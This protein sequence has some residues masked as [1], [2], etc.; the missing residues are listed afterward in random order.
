[1]ITTQAAEAAGLQG[2]FWEMHDLIFA[3]QGEWSAL[4]TLDT[5]AWLTARAAELGLDAQRFSADLNSEAMIKKA[6]DAQD[7]ARKA[8]IGGTP[9]L[10]VNGKPY[11]G[12]RSAQALT[13]LVNLVDFIPRQFTACPPMTI[14]PAKTY[15]ATLT[16][17]KGDIVIE[18][19]PDKA[20][21]TVNSF[22]F[23]ARSGWFDNVTF[24]RVIPNFA[25]QTG[26][27]TGTG[28][29]NPGYFF[30]NEITPELTYSEPGMV[31][32]ANGGPG[33]NGSQFF[34]TYSAQQVLNGKYTVFGKVI[35]GME[36]VQ[37]L[38][39]RDP[40]AG[41]ALPDPDQIIKVSIQEK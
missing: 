24:H 14:D 23:L 33:T 6:Q 28:K 31:G 22:I 11:E 39:P 18:L 10:L 21:V 15:T 36:V 7:T 20:P 9:F 16:T 26:D 32:M 12:S 2:K 5:A 29:G 30:D 1:M 27:P 19:Y 8:G 38:T 35:S 40:S 25:A 17:S 34:I 13:D 4:S 3:R 41:G 37:Q